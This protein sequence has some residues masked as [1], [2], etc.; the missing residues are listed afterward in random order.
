MKK[1]R[2]QFGVLKIPRGVRVVDGG[3]VDGG[4]LVWSTEDR[5][6]RDAAAQEP[7]PQQPQEGGKDGV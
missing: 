3:L 4:D 2:H 1:P 5:R 6:R 7:Q